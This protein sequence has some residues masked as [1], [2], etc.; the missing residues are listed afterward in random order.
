MPK[1]CSKAALPVMMWLH[2]E[3]FSFPPSDCRSCRQAKRMAVCSTGMS[4]VAYMKAYCCPYP[5]RRMPSAATTHW[6]FVCRVPDVVS[7]AHGICQAPSLIYQ[8]SW[9]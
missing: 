6:W 1:R 9:Q 8:G 3:G 7:S 2:H 5:L 4:M